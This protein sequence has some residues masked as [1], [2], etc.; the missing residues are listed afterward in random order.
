[1]KINRDSTKRGG[2]EKERERKKEKRKKKKKKKICKYDSNKIE[3]NKTVK[4]P[5]ALSVVTIFNSPSSLADVLVDFVWFSVF[6]NA[7]PPLKK[8]KP[9]ER[10]QQNWGQ[11]RLGAQKAGGQTAPSSQHKVWGRRCS[12][13]PPSPHGSQAPPFLC[14]LSAERK[15]SCRSLLLGSTLLIMGSDG[16]IFHS[17]LRR[18]SVSHPFSSCPLHAHRRRFVPGSPLLPGPPLCSVSPLP[19]RPTSS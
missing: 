6:F 2:E 8:R 19:A 3:H 17:R 12:H 11:E 7:L 5:P 10:G 18:H 14:Y 16:N 15:P 13:N 9:A 1:M 4:L